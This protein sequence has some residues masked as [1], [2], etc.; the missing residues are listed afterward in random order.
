MAD[1]RVG[2]TV[3]T[4]PE[5]AE[6]MW[7]LFPQYLLFNLFQRGA[8][9]SFCL[10]NLEETGLV[11]RGRERDKFIL[12]TYGTL[13]SRSLTASAVKLSRGTGGNPRNI[14]CQPPSQPERDSL[15]RSVRAPR[16]TRVN[17]AAS[18]VLT[19]F[20]LQNVKDGFNLFVVNVKNSC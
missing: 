15:W 11:T 18:P 10:N 9:C 5:L 4:S 14:L 16:A 8:P 12:G 19:R 17:S 1:R 7:T 13:A 6:G 3:D 20:F 2:G